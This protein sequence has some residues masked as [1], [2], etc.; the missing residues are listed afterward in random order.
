MRERRWGRDRDNLGVAVCSYRYST[1][2]KYIQLQPDS[3]KIWLRHKNFFESYIFFRGLS[4]HLLYNSWD[5][6]LLL[7]LTDPRL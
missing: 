7:L 3:Y 5:R 4:R 1:A 6:S 2:Y